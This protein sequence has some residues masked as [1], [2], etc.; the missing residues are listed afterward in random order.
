MK[1][2]AFISAI[3][4]KMYICLSCPA[5]FELTFI[6]HWTILRIC[7]VLMQNVAKCIWLPLIYHLLKIRITI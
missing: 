1:K 3:P 2:Q 6:A 5:R 7:S 4:R